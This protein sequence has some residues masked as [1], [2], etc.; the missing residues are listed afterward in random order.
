MPDGGNALAPLYPQPPSNTIGNLGLPQVVGIAEGLQRLD[1]AKFDLDAK[2]FAIINDF[3][4]SQ[5]TNPNLSK[6][7]LASWATTFGRYFP[8]LPTAA[9]TGV[10]NSL[11]D[12][13]AGLQEQAKN[14]AKAAMGSANLNINRV[15]G[16]PNPVTGESTTIPVGTAMNSGVGRGGSAGL[17]GQVTTGLPPGSEASIGRMHKD[18]GNTVDFG[19]DMLPMQQAYDAMQRLKQK[20]GEGYFAPGAKGRQ[21][22][23]AFFYGIAPQLS[24]M[25]GGDPEKIRDFAEA[26]KYLKQAVAGR[27]G[28]FGAGT[29]EQLKLAVGGSPGVEIPDMATEHVVKMMMAA[30]RME[31]AQTL[32]ASQFG[33]PNY[34][35]NAGNIATQ[36][37]P[38]AFMVDLMSG[39][40]I[41]KLER[42]LTGAARDNFNASLALAMKTGAISRE[43]LQQIMSSAK[44]KTPKQSAT[45]AS[46]AE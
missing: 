36:L 5:A 7:D 13:P 22:F 31:H 35:R 10:I 44:A 21:D 39:D 19:Q 20:Y 32:T 25:F 11:P 16:P 26:D 45:A 30:R 29:Q 6:K 24:K 34:T 41:R 27:V 1:T 42:G 12:D 15:T 2:R 8:N 37:V 33:G 46:N 14:L 9:L 3:I 28:G 4:G 23:M 18:L 40:E 38:Q 17:P 43:K